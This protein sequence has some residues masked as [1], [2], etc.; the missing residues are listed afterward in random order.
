MNEQKPSPI[1]TAVL[2]L[3]VFLDI[4]NF[5]MPVPIYTPLFL[6][7]G[8]VPGVSEHTA[9]ILLG[10]LVA[11]FGAA[12]LIGGPILGELS[13]K[14]GRK[15]V[16]LGA[17]FL[18]FIGT[19]L[20]AVSLS[21]HSV[22]LLYI[23]RIVIG[24]SSGTIGISYA[25]AADHCSPKNLSK[26][27]GIISVGPCLASA[28]SPIIGG[29]LVDNVTLSFLGY[30]TPF[31]V[32]AVVFLLNIILIHFVMPSDEAKNKH[33]KLTPFS[34]FTNIAK[35]MN[36]SSVLRRMV[37]MAIFFQIGTEGCFLAIP[38]LAVKVFHLSPSDIANYFLLFALSSTFASTYLNSL[39][40]RK[41][42]STTLYT[43]FII[44]MLLGISLIYTHS[45]FLFAIAFLLFGAGGMLCWIHTNNLFSSLVSEKEQGMIMGVSQAMWSLGGVISSLL[46]GTIATYHTMATGFVL[47][48][49]ELISLLMMFGV[50]RAMKPKKE[51]NE[52]EL[53]EAY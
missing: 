27:I 1:L 14:Y 40:S 52:V 15:K 32:I 53:A 8:F 21:V 5:F 7:T 44:V 6:N 51:A 48:P 16:I 29:H 33:I 46:I 24:F 35:V 13:D 43:I 42:K 26:Y 9:L 38:I 45:S 41:F 18:G 50:M 37:L 10:I 20:A 34:A 12:Q 4:C 49:T 2:V 31:A 11:C 28:I 3:T 36:R 19:T 25:V 23:S 17:L 22:S 30:A 47:I 39:L